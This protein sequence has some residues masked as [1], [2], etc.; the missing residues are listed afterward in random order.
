MMDEDI[1]KYDAN[2]YVEANTSDFLLN[3]NDLSTE[4]QFGPQN[5]GT[6]EIINGMTPIETKNQQITLVNGMLSADSISVYVS[7]FDNTEI[8]KSYFS[9]VV[10]E[11]ISKGGYSEVDTGREN[12]FAKEVKTAY[13]GTITT[14]NCYMGNYFIKISYYNDSGNDISFFKS[15]IN[16]IH[17]KFN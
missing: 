10:N 6:P 7:K 13:F 12:C 2:K 9:S 11:I 15:I 1:K 8:T 17:N 14:A 16:I 5:T 3:R 4:W